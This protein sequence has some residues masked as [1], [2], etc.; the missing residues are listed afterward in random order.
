MLNSINS[1]FG[2]RILAT[3]GEA[4]RIRDVYI[5]D[6]QW[7]VRYLVVDT[8]KWL[9]EKS[10]LILPSAVTSMEQEPRAIK[11]N[12]TRAEVDLSPDMSTHKPVSRQLEAR[13]WPYASVWAWGEMSVIVPLETQVRLRQEENGLEDQAGADAHL[14]S[15]RMV[16]G[17][18]IQATNDSIGHVADFLYDEKTWAIRYLIADTRNWLPGKH[19]LIS[20]QTV[21]DVDWGDREFRVSLTRRQIEQSPEYDADHLTSISSI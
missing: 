5:D 7:T 11:V 13:Y 9:N 3:D 2:F 19:V 12:L 17:Y 8:C 21:N 14:R 4:G 1:L 10:V 6:R 20:P 15:G 16:R 18:H